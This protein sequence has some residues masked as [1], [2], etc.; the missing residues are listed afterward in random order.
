MHTAFAGF[1]ERLEVVHADIVKT[2]AGLPQ[3]ALDWVPG[4]DMNSLA[5][6]AAHVAGAERYWIGDVI[7]Q[8]S[9][10][11]DRDLE[12]ETSGLPEAELTRRL[13]AALEHS[14]GV[15]AALSPDQLAEERPW[16]KDGSR[17][18]SVSNALA[19]TLEHTGIHLGHMQMIRQLW[20]QRAGQ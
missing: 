2:F 17:R 19:H 12:F 3:E 20:D 5:V 10:D 8:D 11:R 14:R 9:S 16:G 1:I 6:L 13:A 18:C 4:A 7:G 15:L